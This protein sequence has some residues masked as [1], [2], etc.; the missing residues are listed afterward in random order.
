LL[1]IPSGVRIQLTLEII[2]CGNSDLHLYRVN[3]VDD[4][5]QLCIAASLRDLRGYK[6]LFAGPPR[7]A[8]FLVG[9]PIRVIDSNHHRDRSDNG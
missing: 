6:I 7:I 2:E 8:K 9:G 4:T 3:R 1:W 5:I